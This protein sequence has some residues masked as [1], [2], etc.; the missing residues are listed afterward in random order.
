MKRSSLRTILLAAPIIMLVTTTCMRSD[1]F[2]EVSRESIDSTTFAKS[3]TAISAFRESGYELEETGNKIR[4]S[5]QNHEQTF[6]N[7]VFIKYF[8]ENYIGLITGLPTFDAGWRYLI[9][10]TYSD[11]VILNRNNL[12][13]LFRKRVN[14]AVSDLNLQNGYVYFEY[15]EYPDL[16]YGRFSFSE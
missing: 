12:E 10:P 5:Y 15:G 7:V 11:L 14:E 9:F 6:P 2:E 16:K 13:I 1:Q 8:D 3:N 4:L